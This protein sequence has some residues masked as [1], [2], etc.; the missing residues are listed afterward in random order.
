MIRSRFARAVIMTAI[1]AIAL[2]AVAQQVP[3]AAKPTSESAPT[4]AAA[5]AEAQEAAALEAQ[6]TA[7]LIAKANAAAA[8]NTRKGAATAA[9][10]P[11]TSAREARK[12]ANEY[13]FH[14]EVFNGNTLFCR[15]DAVLGTRFKTKRCMGLDQF[16]DYA[17]QLEIARDTINAK[18]ACSGGICGELH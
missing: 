16:A 8:A 9:A 2:P 17:T 18:T 12:R 6:E 5:S 10:T 14:A 13:G 15:D 7:A 1:S 3:E 4:S 11:A